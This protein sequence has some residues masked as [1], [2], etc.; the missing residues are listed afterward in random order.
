MQLVQFLIDETI[1]LLWTETS[2]KVLSQGLFTLLRL[3]KLQPT[4]HLLHL[5]LI[6]QA[7]E[8]CFTGTENIEFFI[9]IILFFH[10]EGFCVE[11]NAI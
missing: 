5:R 3:G 2:H 1:I 11:L 9:L 4:N 10:F 7:K 8:V 6:Q